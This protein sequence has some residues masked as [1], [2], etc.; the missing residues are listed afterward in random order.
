MPQILIEIDG[1][2]TSIE[3]ALAIAAHQFVTKHETILTPEQAEP[4][5]KAWILD[6]IELR[7]NDIDHFRFLEEIANRKDFA[8]AELKAENEMLKAA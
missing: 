1:E 3:N 6:A 2:L 7:L 4:I 5:I 8:K